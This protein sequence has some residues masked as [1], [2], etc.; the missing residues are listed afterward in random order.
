MPTVKT[1]EQARAAKKKAIELF[2]SIAPVT[3][4]GITK[5]D[6]GYGLKVNLRRKPARGT[7]VLTDVVG[8]PVQVEVTGPIRKRAATPGSGPR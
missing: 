3:G 8:V 5:I 1:L 7:R 6:G 2:S 4:V